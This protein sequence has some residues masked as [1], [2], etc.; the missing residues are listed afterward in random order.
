MSKERRVLMVV[1]NLDVGGLERIVVDMA[2]RLAQR[3]HKVCVVTLRHGGTLAPQL[4]EQ[5]IGVEELGLGDGIRLRNVAQL[6]SQIKAFKPDVVH[7][8]GEA[9]LFYSASCRLSGLHFRHVHTRH[10]YE[11][12]SNKGRIRNRLS[13]KGCDAVV[14]V[15]DDLSQH[16]KEREGVDAS[17]LFTVVNGV[18]L[19]P[20]RALPLMDYVP[21]EPIIGHVARL[22]EVKNQH[23]L[24]DAFALLRKRLTAAR[25]EIVGDGPMRAQLEAHSRTLGLEKV[26]RFHGESD[27]IPE[28]LSNCHLF[29]LSSDSEGTPVSVL[30]ALAAGRPVVATAVGGLPSVISQD[31]GVLCPPGDAA[32]LAEGL[33]AVY[34]AADV[35]HGYSAAAR[36]SAG[37][38]QD[39]DSMLSAYLSIY[40]P[41]NAR[42]MPANGAA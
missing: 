23:L 30:E 12:V 21:L 19:A 5:G 39:L 4:R 35:Y 18:D 37:Q 6:R 10:G 16:C 41:Q 14:C 32:A 11:D 31:I 40:D 2:L 28:K 24:L 1:L 15:S 20:Y 3:A 33:Y 38:T 9:A 17:K 34:E 36:S 42:T 7:S 25:L 22:V 29:C 27:G 26:V 8:H 13:F